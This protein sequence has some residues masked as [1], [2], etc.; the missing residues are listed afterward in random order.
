MRKQTINFYN[1]VL[2]AVFVAF[3]VGCTQVPQYHEVTKELQVIKD[4][5]AYYEGML[6]C[7]YVNMTDITI[8][9][10]NDP[11]SRLEKDVVIIRDS[12]DDEL[13]DIVKEYPRAYYTYIIHSIK[14]SEILRDLINACIKENIGMSFELTFNSKDT[15][16][17]NIDEQQ[18]ANLNEEILKYLVESLRLSFE[19][20][21]S[22]LPELFKSPKIDYDNENI[23]I[24]IGLD[25]EAIIDEIK[26]SKENKDEI[27]QVLLNILETIDVNDINISGIIDADRG[28]IFKFVG[29][30]K[31]SS[32]D[33]LITNEEIKNFEEKYRKEIEK[34]YSE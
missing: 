19:S 16:Y 21:Q 15:H 3:F 12:L 28:L 23:S 27:K 14:K 24:S 18:L 8:G 2:T 5:I 33:I 29:L 31:G 32:V 9:K 22:S 13:Y 7:E 20:N 4:S 25:D 11:S 1:S 26:E 10:I 30:S 17:F 34:F 6:M